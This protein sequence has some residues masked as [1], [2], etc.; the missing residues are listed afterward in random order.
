[1]KFFEILSIYLVLNLGS[2]LH[3]TFIDSFDILLLHFYFTSVF[4][5]SITLAIAIQKFAFR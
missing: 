2:L 1:M 4:M 3:G 5:V